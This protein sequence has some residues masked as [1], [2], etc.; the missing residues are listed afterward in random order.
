M[1][2]LIVGATSAIAEACARLWAQRGDSLFLAARDTARL[3][4]IATDLRVRG[5]ATV[6]T[7]TFDALAHDT[8]AALLE[9]A[10]SALGGLDLV[11]IAHGSLPDQAR[12][13]ADAGAALREIDVNALSV[14]SLATHAANRLEVQ[15]SG[16]LAIIGS[17]AGDRG[18][19][20]NYVYGAA[21]A[22]VDTF[23]AGLRHRL[24]A[25]GVRVILIKPGF[26][27][28]PMTEAFPKGPLWA[29]PADIAPRI[30]RAIDRGNGV[31]YVPAFWRLIMWI[32]RSVPERIFLRTKL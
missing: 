25:R 6:E 17:V 19:Q 9:R 14:V 8:H 32:I 1:K 24:H 23:A 5:A 20:S 31:L 29:A 30:V 11:F 10:H 27:D 7:G 26:V 28:T 18:R 13:A 22:L 21:K 3:E 15:G 4:G 12:C 2:I 16:A